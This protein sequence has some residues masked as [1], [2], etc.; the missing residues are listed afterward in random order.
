MAIKATHKFPNEPVVGL[1]PLLRILKTDMGLSG[2][3]GPLVVLFTSE[4]RGIP[5]SGVDPD[6]IGK[7]ESWIPC[8]TDGVWLPTT[9]TLSFVN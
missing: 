6:R 2:T 3:Y 8:M 5:L 4:N 1:F 9:I 7:E